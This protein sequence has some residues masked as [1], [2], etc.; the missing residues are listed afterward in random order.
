MYFSGLYLGVLEPNFLWACLRFEYELIWRTK[1]Y[2]GCT[3]NVKQ[4]DFYLVFEMTFMLSGS[5]L[6][7]GLPHLACVSALLK[8]PGFDNPYFSGSLIPGISTFFMLS[9][10][11]F[12]NF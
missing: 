3:K 5:I 11:A 7:S 2:K 9:N 4:I 10:L 12:S 8:F 1:D 6:C